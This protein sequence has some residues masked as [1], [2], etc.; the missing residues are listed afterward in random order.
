MPYMNET[1]I[2]GHAGRDAEFSYSKDGKGIC[3]LSV[4]V[5]R[6]KDREADWFN[7]VCF[8]KTAEIA[9]E[10]RKGATVL[11]KGSMQAN[12]YQD[13][14]YWN[15]LANRIYTFSKTSKQEP[16]DDWNDFGQDVET[17]DEIPF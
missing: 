13:K 16:R 14:T 5:S 9:S 17:D 11:V 6:G 4:A 1:T 7:I 12:K 10:I 2:L 8:G 3:K 15:L